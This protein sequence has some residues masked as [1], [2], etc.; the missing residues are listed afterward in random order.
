MQYK[1]YVRGHGGEEPQKLPISDSAAIDL[2]TIGDMGSTMSDE[3]A[4]STIFSH[5][6]VSDL[7]QQIAGSKIIYWSKLERDRYYYDG[8]LEYSKPK[9]TTTL[10]DNIYFNLALDG[11]DDIGTCG[12]CYWNTE[13]AEL[14][15]LA[16]VKDGETILLSQI[17]ELLKNILNEGDSAQLFWT[18][19]MSGKYW[20]GTARKVSFN[21]TNK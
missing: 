8:L 1:V 21:P 3:V 14:V 5:R 20:S 16:T 12:V 18:A 11:S 9:L 10:Y 2:I 13:K 7:E 4:D 19:C 17:L 15:W 6:G